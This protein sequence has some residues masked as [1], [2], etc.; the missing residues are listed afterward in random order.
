MAPGATLLLVVPAHWQA[1]SCHPSGYP[2]DPAWTLAAVT[3]PSLDKE[4]MQV[5]V[6]LTR[7]HR[8]TDSEEM[9]VAMVTVVTATGMAALTAELARARAALLQNC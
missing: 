2:F 7:S 1:A 6:R 9:M 3:A 8:Q 4:A 5:S